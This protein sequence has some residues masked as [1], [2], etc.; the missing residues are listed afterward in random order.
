MMFHK[1][2]MKGKE[3]KKNLSRGL[4]LLQKPSRGKN[5]MAAKTK[6]MDPE[7]KVKGQLKAS[8]S[9]ARSEVSSYSYNTDSEEEDESMKEGWPLHS[10]LSIPAGKARRPGLY[11]SVSKKSRQSC[12]RGLPSGTLKSKQAVSKNKHKHFALL[13]QEAEARSSFSDS[14][15]DSFD[16]GY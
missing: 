16:Q 13:L 8:Y 5:K 3:G 11:S 15:E 10:M 6:N 7:I 4:G 14:S 12:K 9:P 2:E 1:M